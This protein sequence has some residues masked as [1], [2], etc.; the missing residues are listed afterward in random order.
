VDYLGEPGLKFLLNTKEFIG[1]KVFFTGES[2]RETNAALRRLVKPGHIV[3][4]AG[5]NNGSETVLLGRLVGSAGKVYAFEPVPHLV[6]RLRM[7]L[8]LNDIEDRVEV[9]ELA[10][11][12][13]ESVV[14][15][16]L[17][18]KS[19]VN[20][21]MSSK[22]RFAE[23]REEIEV[24]QTTLD[25]WSAHVNLPRLD[26]LKMDIQGSELEL[27]AGGQETINRCRPLIFTEADSTAQGDGQHTVGDLWKQLSDLG[28]S[29]F[30][31]TTAEWLPLPDA[32]QLQPGNWVALPKGEP[33]TAWGATRRP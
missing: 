32:H 12:E 8:V 5:A 18:P 3:L 22:W 1:W 9:C 10:L 17:T 33:P 26:F 30:R 23:A 13:T 20:Q 7:N 14:K 29:M 15:F 21:G 24:R 16:F 27:L 25:Q 11:G 28:Y 6:K 31:L 4:E 2:E 19:A